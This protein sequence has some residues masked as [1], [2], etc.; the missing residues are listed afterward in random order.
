MVEIKRD[1]YLN[2]LIE[3]EGNGLVKIITGIRRCGKSYLLFELFRKHLLANGVKE[4]HIICLSLGD[5]ENEEYLDPA[6]LSQ[7]LK[8]KI[9]NEEEKFY[10][11]LDE[12]QLLISDE[13][14]KSKGRVKLHSILNSLLKH[15]AGVANDAI[16]LP[17]DYQFKGPLT[18][19]FVLQQLLGRFEVEPR[20]YAD[21]NGEID[22]LLQSGTEIIPLEVKGGEGKSAPGFKRYITEHKPKHALRLSLRGYRKDGDFTNIPLYLAGKIRT[23]L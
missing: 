21:K 1:R 2:Q 14:Y 22:F 5:D 4:D 9:S 3:K 23:L 13:E 20:D 10:F 19:N 18:E 8:S 7:Y 11:L 15:M 12:V 16:L 17:M 6:K